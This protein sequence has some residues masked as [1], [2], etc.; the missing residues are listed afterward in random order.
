MTA[1]TV[2]IA[3]LKAQLSK[4]VR[5]ASGGEEIGVR[6]HSRVVA[7][8]VQSQSGLPLHAENPAFDTLRRCIVA[9]LLAT[10][11]RHAEILNTSNRS[12][13]PARD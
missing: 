13:P 10:R 3:E 8:L 2:G 9:E 7:R 5:L 6:D 12:A 1:M 11:F 4:Y